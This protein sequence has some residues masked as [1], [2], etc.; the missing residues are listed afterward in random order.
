MNKFPFQ[1]KRGHKS[2]GFVSEAAIDLKIQEHMECSG[3]K[4]GSSGTG[5]RSK[6]VVPF[7]KRAHAMV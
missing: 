7:A 3:H 5:G 1:W 2:L 4:V 6:L